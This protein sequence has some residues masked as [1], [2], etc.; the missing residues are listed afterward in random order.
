MSHYYP[1]NDVQNQYYNQNAV[2]PPPK[3]AYVKYLAT[4][5]QPPLGP[6]PALRINKLLMFLHQLA[7]LRHT[8]R[9]SLTCIIKVKRHTKILRAGIDKRLYPSP[10]TRNMGTGYVE[11]GSLSGVGG[12]QQGVPS[13]ISGIGS[14]T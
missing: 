4:Y 10:F 2:Y 11:L 1:P 3:T 7:S 5:Q 6:S 12:A 8:A 14:T 9:V 13:R